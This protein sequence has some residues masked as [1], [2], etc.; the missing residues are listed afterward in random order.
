MIHGAFIVFF[1]TVRKNLIF[2]FLRAEGDKFLIFVSSTSCPCICCGDG[3]MLDFFM[4]SRLDRSPKVSLRLIKGDCAFKM[5]NFGNGEEPNSKAQF[6]FEEERRS[7]R[8]RTW[9]N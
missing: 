6:S 9:P 4:G 2:L 1:S 7:R 3:A 5:G 8:S